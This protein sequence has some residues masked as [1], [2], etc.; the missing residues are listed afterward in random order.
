[1]KA[2]RNA[3]PVWWERPALLATS[4]RPLILQNQFGGDCAAEI[5]DLHSLILNNDGCLRAVTAANC[6]AA[7]AASPTMR[8]A[9]RV[10]SGDDA[11]NV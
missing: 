4:L 6:R 1:M 3:M 11:C 10:R 5:E 8:G 2:G 7:H 9:R